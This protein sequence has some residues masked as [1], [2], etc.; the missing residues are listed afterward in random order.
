METWLLTQQADE[1]A[2]VHAHAPAAAW[3][4]RAIVLMPRFMSQVCA[5]SYTSSIRVIVLMCVVPMWCIA[6]LRWQPELI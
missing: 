5:L 2:C 1:L 4:R 3:R 6:M